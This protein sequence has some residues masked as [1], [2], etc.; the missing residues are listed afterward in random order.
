MCTFTYDQL[1][2]SDIF[3]YS[4]VIGKQTDSPLVEAVKIKSS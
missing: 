1:F 2:N 3:I 4:N